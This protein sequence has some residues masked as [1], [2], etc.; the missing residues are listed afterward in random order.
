MERLDLLEVGHGGLS[1]VARVEQPLAEQLLLGQHIGDTAHP[2]GEKPA[3]QFH[4]E[5]AGQAP[6]APGGGDGDTH[7]PGTLTGHGGERRADRDA[8]VDGDD[9]GLLGGERADALGERE[10]RL[11]AEFGRGVD[12]VDHCREIALSVVVDEPV[13]RYRPSFVPL[14]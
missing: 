11:L 2:G 3:L 14:R 7:H 12:Q 9:G 6:A 10:D 13:H 1:V 4:Q 8:L 5:G